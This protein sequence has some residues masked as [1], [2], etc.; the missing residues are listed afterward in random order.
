MIAALC[1]ALALAAQD[2]PGPDAR[3]VPLER[4][5]P[6]WTDYHAL[7]A[8]E[9]SAFALDYVI[10]LRGGAD[11]QF[12]VETADGFEVLERDPAG[13]ATPPPPEAFEAGQRLFTDAPEGGAS[14][15]M[16]LSLAGEPRESYTIAELETAIA[17]AGNAMRSLMGLRAMFMP[18]LETVRFSFDEAAPEAVIVY[19]DGRQ[20][21]VETVFGDV[22]T[23]RPQD[24]ALRG[25][26]EVRFGAVPQEAVLETSR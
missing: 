22:I 21:P 26:V 16:R 17:Q 9:R 20:A 12:W 15:S 2:A 25:A 3:S 24:R 11:A 1:I 10:S 7:P 23:I 19:E 18:R 5:F 6:F 13:A 14:V 8:D 4:V